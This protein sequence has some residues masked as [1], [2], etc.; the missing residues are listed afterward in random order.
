MLYRNNVCWSWDKSEAFCTIVFE[1]REQLNI[2]L[3]CETK[4][5]WVN[6]SRQVFL[7]ISVI[8][9]VYD[10]VVLE[11]CLSF[12]TVVKLFTNLVTTWPHNNGIASSHFLRWNYVATLFECNNDVINTS[13]GNCI[14]SSIHRWRCSWKSVSFCLFFFACSPFSLRW[15][16]S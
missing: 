4:M 16:I 2:S 11:M 13:Y 1:H 15:F 8:S 3:L 5:E 6:A 14:F 10:S 12:M 7:Y 9:Y